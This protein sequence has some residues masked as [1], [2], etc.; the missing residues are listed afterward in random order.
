MQRCE[1]HEIMTRR[2]WES[3]YELLKEHEDWEKL[4]P[5]LGSFGKHHPP[6]LEDVWNI[7][8]Q[9]W[10]DM[11]LDN[12]NFNKEDLGAYYAHAVWF[13]NGLFIETDE[14]SM[15]H[16]KS[17]ASYF[18]NKTG[19][20]ILDYGGGF[21]TLAKEIAKESPSSQVDIY[22]PHAS[23]Y[24]FK[25]VE[26]FENVEIVSSLETDLYDALVNTDVLEHV[27]DPIELIAT[28]NRGLKPGGLLISHWNFT[29]C[30]KCHLPRNFHYEYTFASSIVPTLGFSREIQNSKHGHFFKKVE[31]VTE[32]HLQNAYR[33]ATLSK[34]LY[35]LNR[36]I[37][38]FK[39]ALVKVLKKV[40]LYNFLKQGLKKNEDITP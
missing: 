19:L 23:D 33:K 30:I 34:K 7:M 36:T 28:Y 3:V 17:I 2:S 18:R 15:A 37:H 12:R 5:C 20:K 35:P 1:K 40:R 16:R 10:D 8:N 11:G 25:N 6:N 22:E 32:R 24:A 4:E 27:E 13:F 26:S 29:P 38:T 39:L 31:D 21:G 14:Q 9:V